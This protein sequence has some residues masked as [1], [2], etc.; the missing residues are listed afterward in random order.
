MTKNQKQ[1]LLWTLVA[2]VV[3]A[4]LVG[5]LVM[6]AKKPGKYDT[7]AQCIADSGAT[8]YGA[9]WCPHCQAQKAMFGKSAKLLPY[10]ECSEPDGTGQLQVCIDKKIEGYPAW[11]FADGS[12]ES[13]QQTLEE[14]A[15][16]TSCV[17]DAQ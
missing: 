9:F 17:I 12:R 5:L 11:I 2:L 10:V 8:F 13:G 15:A 4:G 3:I 1:N 7:F 16:K 14:L 6:Q